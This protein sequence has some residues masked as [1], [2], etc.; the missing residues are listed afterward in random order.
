LILIF[1]LPG[2]LAYNIKQNG[3]KQR[4][5]EAQMN[6]ERLSLAIQ[7]SNDGIWDWNVVTNILYFSPRWCELLGYGPDELAHDFATWE[8]LL[9]PDERDWV[10]DNVRQHLEKHIPYDSRHRMQTKCGEYRWFRSRGKALWDEAGRPL[11][12]AGSLTD[13]S[14]RMNEEKRLLDALHQLQEATD[15]LVQYEKQT[16]IARFAAG[17]AHE[18]LNPTTIISSRLQIMEANND[19][20]EKLKESLRICREQIQRIVNISNDLRQSAHPHPA[21]RKLVNIG[22]VI[23]KALFVM[24]AS[25]VSANVQYVLDVPLTIPMI[26]LDAD[27][28]ERLMINLI[29]NALDAMEGKEGKFLR[30]ALQEDNSSIER[31]R[32]LIS[33]SDNGSGVKEDDLPK[34]FEPFFT[35]KA[36][37]KGTGLGLSVCY[38]I[39]TEHGGKI[40]AENNKVGGATFII[41]LPVK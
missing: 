10:L 34:F 36:P 15:L 6:D 23:E 35:T 25:L 41:S 38:G 20:S 19:L 16:T 27:K 4:K 39:V 3:N 21:Q 22:V 32:I 31:N 2:N 37:G 14:E 30:I 13:I 8:S 1:T 18:I 24:D 9:H 7:G 33:V 40:W 11:R 5:E 28:I 29:F 17:V 12:M 26:N